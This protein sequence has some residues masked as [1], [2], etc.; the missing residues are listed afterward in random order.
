MLSSFKNHLESMKFVFK[1][2]HS[3][4]CQKDDIKVE[5]ALCENGS[6]KEIFA[7]VSVNRVREFNYKWANCLKTLWREKFQKVSLSEENF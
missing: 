6:S 2:I 4:V 3:I 1:K 5:L 7:R